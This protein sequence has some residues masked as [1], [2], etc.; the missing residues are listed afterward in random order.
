MK[1]RYHLAHLLRDYECQLNRFEKLFL[2]IIKRPTPL[3]HNKHELNYLTIELLNRYRNFNRAFLFSC[4]TGAKTTKNNIVGVSGVL[5]EFDFIQTVFSTYKNKQVDAS[6]RT[7]NS[8]DEPAWESDALRIARLL[9]FQNE[10][11]VDTAFTT[12]SFYKHLKIFRNFCGH[13]SHPLFKD[14]ANTALQYNLNEKSI[15]RILTTQSP[16]DGY[17]ILKW[18]DACKV[19]ASLICE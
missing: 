1:R 5:D 14:V 18:I 2:E 6:M 19:Y 4:A 12:S 13:R 17:L 10:V 7:W 9:Q 15:E 8:R 11:S 16:S 3:P